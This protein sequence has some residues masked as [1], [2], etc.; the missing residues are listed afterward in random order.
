MCYIIFRMKDTN[1]LPQSIV[2]IGR[3]WFDSNG[4]TYHTSTI[5]INGEIAHKTPREYGYG[6]Q[7]AYTA[8]EWMLENGIIP[9]PAHKGEV[10]FHYIREFLKIPYTYIGIDVPTKSS[11]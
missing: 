10:H 5:I 6:D 1:T 4:N 8:C 9:K 3:R 11:L 7:Y 2:V